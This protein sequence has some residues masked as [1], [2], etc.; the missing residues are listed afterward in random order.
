MVVRRASQFLG[1]LG[2]G[3]V[4]DPVTCNQRLFAAAS[5]N[6]VDFIRLY[7]TPVYGALIDYA[8]ALMAETRPGGPASDWGVKGVPA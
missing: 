4:D 8:Y 7:N 1:T 3:E 6:E 2:Q 5:H